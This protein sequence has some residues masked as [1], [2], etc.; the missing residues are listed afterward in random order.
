LN[1]GGWY[2]NSLV[3]SPFLPSGYIFFFSWNF[4]NGGMKDL[5]CLVG[6]GKATILLILHET[7]LWN[8]VLNFWPFLPHVIVSCHFS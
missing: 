4:E 6:I 5:E 8:S 2:R 3:N 1:V 7:T